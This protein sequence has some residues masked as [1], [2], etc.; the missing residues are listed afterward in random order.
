LDCQLRGIAAAKID[1]LI[2]GG[3]LH[4]P[5]GIIARCMVLV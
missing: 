1:E 4:H 2:F 5:A 3:E